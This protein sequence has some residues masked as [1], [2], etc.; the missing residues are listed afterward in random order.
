MNMNVLPTCISVQ[1]VC[2]PGACRSQK[3]V[4]SP[5][6]GIVDGCEIPHGVLGALQEQQMVML[7]ILPFKKRRNLINF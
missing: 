2:K 7:H 1:Y 3:R 4:G 6:A 5:G